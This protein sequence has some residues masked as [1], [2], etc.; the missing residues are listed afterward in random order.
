MFSQ[1]SETNSAI[2]D[3]TLIERK[4]WTGHTKQIHEIYRSKQV[5]LKW[6]NC[7]LLDKVSISNEDIN[8]GGKQRKAA[9][10]FAR[11]T[12]EIYISHQAKASKEM[13][14]NDPSNFKEGPVEF[15]TNEA[16][17]RSGT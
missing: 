16:K 2:E 14:F 13:F 7:L 15:L 8:V 1:I 11:V 17:G 4:K 12:Y 3:A 6:K 10:V 9:I 5:L